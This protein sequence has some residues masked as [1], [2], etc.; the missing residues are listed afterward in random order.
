MMKK[1]SEELLN[2]RDALICK[3]PDDIA[4]AV[5]HWAVADGSR[6]VAEKI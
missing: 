3:E 1:M 5:S 2:R 6:H 4:S